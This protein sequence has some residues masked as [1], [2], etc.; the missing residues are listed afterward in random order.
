MSELLDQVRNPPVK[1]IVALALGET[2]SRKATPEL[3]E[4]LKQARRQG[5]WAAADALIAL[6][7]A[8]IIPELIQWYDETISEADRERIVYILGWM[9]AE[10]ARELLPK[11]LT[12]SRRKL[13]GRAVDLMWLL[14]PAAGDADFLMAQLQRIVNSDPEHPEALGLWADEWVQKRLVRTIDKTCLT[15]ALPDLERLQIHVASRAQ[16][17]DPVERPKLEKSI[18]EAIRTLRAFEAMGKSVESMH[19]NN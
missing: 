8:A 18:R 14:S 3:L 9:H 2:G 11:A 16:P 1:S 17:P 7:D 10:R 4:M 6:N 15:A 12:S 5:S 19:N 13:V